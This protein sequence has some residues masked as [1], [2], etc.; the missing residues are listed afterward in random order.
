MCA[1]GTMLAV[2]ATGLEFNR[3]T[4]CLLAAAFGRG[5]WRMAY[6]PCTNF[7]FVALV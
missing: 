7:R 5:M 1:R 2:A 3:K 4:G 6:G